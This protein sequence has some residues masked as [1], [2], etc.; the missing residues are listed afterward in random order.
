FLWTCSVKPTLLTSSEMSPTYLLNLKFSSLNL[1]PDSISLHNVSVSKRSFHFLI[2][3]S[4]NFLEC[5]SCD[6]SSFIWFSIF[7]LYFSDDEDLVR[8]PSLVMCT[9]AL[10]VLPY[11]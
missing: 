3:K 10:P 9:L 2:F 7:T 5:S 1:V 8:V 11:L 6:S 4:S